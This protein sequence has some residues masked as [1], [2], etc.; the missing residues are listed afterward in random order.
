M[1][2]KMY[3]AGGTKEKMFRGY[4]D[5][6]K[7]EVRDFLLTLAGDHAGDTKAEE[8][9]RRRGERV[10]GGVGVGSWIFGVVVVAILILAAAFGWGNF[11]GD[12]K[13]ACCQPAAVNCA[14]PCGGTATTA[15]P[16]GGV[17]IITGGQVTGPTSQQTRAQCVEKG[18]AAMMADSGIKA[19]IEGGSLT[20][21][22]LRSIANTNCGQ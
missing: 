16:A 19:K 8:D 21:E 7:A 11:G 14:N 12:D 5:P 18:I 15:N 17:V 10:I 20:P 13:S 3:F 1:A 2:D 6:E 9:H 22:I 4:F